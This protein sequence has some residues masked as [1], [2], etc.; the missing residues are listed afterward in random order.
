MTS[1][2]SQIETRSMLRKRR[3]DEAF[4]ATLP[5]RDV[6]VVCLLCEDRDA[7]ISTNCRHK[8]YC[9]HCFFASRMWKLH[10]KICERC[11]N[12]T[13]GYFGVR[14][15]AAVDRLCNEAGAVSV[16]PMLAAALETTAPTNCSGTDIVDALCT[17]FCSL[18]KDGLYPLITVDACERLLLEGQRLHMYGRRD[19]HKIKSAL[20]SFCRYPWRVDVEIG[21]QGV[22]YHGNG[23]EI[24][25]LAKGVR[26]IDTNLCFIKGK[27][28]YY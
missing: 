2:T 27:E 1:Q 6:P 4:V 3:A 25:D 12:R 8:N 15:E 13:F 19:G 16:V 22:C 14:V 11:H 20:V 26:C 5:K 21:S 10:S 17:A 28:K 9:A 23:G 24:P 7:E 18:E